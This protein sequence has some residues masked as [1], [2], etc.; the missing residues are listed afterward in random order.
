MPANAPDTTKPEP[1]ANLKAQAPAADKRPVV[2][3]QHGI[4]RTDNSA[5]L[6]DDNWQQVL[7]EPEVLKPEVRSHLEA[8]NTYYS[9]ATDDLA[10]LREQLFLEMRGRIKED[11]SSVP[12]PHGDYL[13]SARYRKGGDYPVYV[14]TDRQGQNE[15]ILFDGDSESGDADF[16]R[17]GSVSQSPDHSMIAH[18]VDRLG[19][20]NYDVRVRN[21]ATGDEFEETVGSTSGYVV[22]ASDS[23]SFFYV[24]RDENQRPK[25][26]RR[27]V[28][29]T[30]PANDELVYEEPDDTYFLGISK[31]QS[32]QYVMMTSGKSTSS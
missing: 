12:K 2:I 28:L 11:D 29:D 1:F 14:R 6:K 32:D 17:I 3:E 8:E 4:E 15:Q 26:V 21:I 30:D 24:E 25:R 9:A 19:S 22:W 20:E 18:A 7:R 13:Y 16:F 10:A 23:K 31:T 27:H 5:W